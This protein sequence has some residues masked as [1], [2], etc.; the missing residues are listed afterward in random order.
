MI[1]VFGSFETFYLF[2]S[3]CGSAIKRMCLNPP[4]VVSYFILLSE[5]KENRWQ[6]KNFQPLRRPFP[7]SMIFFCFVFIVIS[8]FDSKNM[9]IY[10]DERERECVLSVWICQLVVLSVTLN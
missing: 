3:F 7:I 5:I 9:T 1:W 10:T 8:L 6:L 4:Q 2:L